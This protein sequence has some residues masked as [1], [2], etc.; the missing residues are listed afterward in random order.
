MFSVNHVKALLC[1]LLVGL[2]GAI[3]FVPVVEGADDVRA[4]FILL[5]GIAVRDY[6]GSTQEDKRVA[7]LEQAYNPQPP[8]AYVPGEGE[9]DR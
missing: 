3:L 6:F 9:G 4:M 5:T 7:G 1:F 2:T 8:A